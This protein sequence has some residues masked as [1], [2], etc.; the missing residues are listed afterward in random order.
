MSTP[1]DLFLGDLHS[2]PEKEI[3]DDTDSM[4]DRVKNDQIQ[5]INQI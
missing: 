5:V 1:V 2:T 3:H 4:N